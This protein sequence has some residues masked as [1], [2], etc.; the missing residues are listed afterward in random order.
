MR[1]TAPGVSFNARAFSQVKAASRITPL[2]GI[3]C[4]SNGGAARLRSK[5][6]LRKVILSNFTAPGDIVMLTVAVRDPVVIRRWRL[7]QDIAAHP[8]LRRL[9]LSEC[10]STGE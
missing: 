5:P 2:A 8:P 10:Q 7:A 4:R 9:P 1:F 6:K 3:Q